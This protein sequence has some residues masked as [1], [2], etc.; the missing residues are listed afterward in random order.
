VE[1][2]P[3]D[4]CILILAHQPIKLACYLS[5]E[6][7]FVGDPESLRPINMHKLRHISVATEKD[8]LLPSMD[9]EQLKI[10]T[11]KRLSGVSL[12]VDHLLLK[13]LQNLRVFYLGG[14]HV[15]SIPSYIRSLIHLCLLNLDGTDISC[16][17]ES[18]G[19]LKN[20]QILNLQRCA[21]LQS[22]PLAVTPLCNL[23]R[24]G[25]RDTPINLVPKGIYKLKFL[26]DLEGFLAGGGS[27]NAKTQNGWKLDELAH[28]SH[29]IPPATK[30]QTPLFFPL[31]LLYTS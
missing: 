20:L 7:C 6:E 12:V 27:D 18:I 21:Y 10:R 2:S 25:L 22:L 3:S 9:K 19:S 30:V 31:S 11:F 4:E 16:L 26:N 23:R 5:K 17:P 13:K 15:L 8:M 1:T 14:S 29:A 24:L 28:L